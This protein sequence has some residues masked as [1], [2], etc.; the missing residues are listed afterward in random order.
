MKKDWPLNT[1][2]LIKELQN[3]LSIT[4][5]DW[6]IDKSNSKRRAAELISSALSQ[7]INEGEVKDIEDLLNQSIK[8]LKK[9]IKDPGCP[10]KK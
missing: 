6:H 5:Q 10:H 1:K 8:W 7:L 2:S 3:N 9:E 4:H